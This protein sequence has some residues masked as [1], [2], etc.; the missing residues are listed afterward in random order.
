MR[1]KLVAEILLLVF[2]LGCGHHYEDSRAWTIVR[3]RDTQNYGYVNEIGF[4]TAGF[5]NRADAKAALD[6]YRADYRTR[7]TIG[8]NELWERQ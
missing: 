7:G 6:R 8:A 5:T 4:V 3:Q 1:A 2:L